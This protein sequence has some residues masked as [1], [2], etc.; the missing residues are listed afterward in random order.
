MPPRPARVPRRLVDEVQMGVEPTEAA[1]VQSPERPGL[2]ENALA[3][4]SLTPAIAARAQGY[5]FASAGLLGASGV[6]LP[7]P[8]RFA[9]AGMLAVQLASIAAAVFLLL[10]PRLAPRRALAVGPYGA[11]VLTSFVLL[12]SGQGTSA[13]LLFYLW[14]AFYAF[15]FLSQRAAAAL[16]L[17]TVLNHVVVLTYFRFA[18]SPGGPAANED[19]SALVLTAG[20]VVVAGVFILL[21]RRRV[22]RLIHQLTDAASTDYLTTLLN[23]RGFQ[24]KLESEVARSTRYG[25]PFSL[26]LGDCDFF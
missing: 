1:S 4:R 22:G 14:V 26:L 16:A 9:E 18:N 6:L 23:R 5:L 10:W 24:E 25:E 20:T 3:I 7:H 11:T 21:L 2:R 12:F 8:K 15:Y 19:I 13:Y 17:F